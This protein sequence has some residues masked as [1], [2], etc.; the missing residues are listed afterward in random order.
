MLHIMSNES[1]STL[2]EVEEQDV[3]PNAV[4]LKVAKIFKI[5]DGWFEIS[6]DEKKHRGSTE[7]IPAYKDGTWW[8]LEPGTY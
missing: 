8:Y 2:T 5:N 7:L 6:N 1:E 4:D 3:Q